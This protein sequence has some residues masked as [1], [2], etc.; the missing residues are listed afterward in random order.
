MPHLFFCIHSSEFENSQEDSPQLEAHVVVPDHSQ[1]PGE[2]SSASEY[3]SCV[4]APGTLPAAA[5]DGK[6]DHKG[7]TG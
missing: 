6:G 2:E 3:F 4:P 1:T 7:W 5:E